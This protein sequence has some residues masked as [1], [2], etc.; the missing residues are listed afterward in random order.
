MILIVRTKW[1]NRLKLT[2]GLALTSRTQALLSD[3]TV[4]PEGIELRCESQFGNGLDKCSRPPSGH[5]WRDHRRRRMF[6]LLSDSGAGSKR[7]LA[8]RVADFSRAPV[9]ASLHFLSSRIRSEPAI[10]D[11]GQARGPPSLQRHDCRLAPRAAPGPVRRVSGADGMVCSGARCCAAA[12]SPPP[13][14]VTVNFISSPRT[15]EHAVELLEN[16][17][18]DA[19]LEPYGSLAKNPKLRR[20]LKDHRREEAD[21]FRRTQ[22]IPVIHTLVL[23][24]ALVAKQPWVAT[25]LLSAFRKARSLA[26]KYIKRRGERGSPVA[27]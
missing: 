2:L 16:G 20:L 18:I 25:S 27:E 24:E 11:Q 8:S 13:K 17:A 9:S 6:D 3:H 22:V 12:T 5:P 21:Y 14:S 15:R 23:Q 7:V 4:R 10:G 19:A 1:L 26:E